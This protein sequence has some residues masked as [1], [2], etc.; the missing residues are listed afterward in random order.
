M[1]YTCE[2]APVHLCGAAAEKCA[3]RMENK[4]IDDSSISSLGTFNCMATSCPVSDKIDEAEKML[5]KTTH[6]KL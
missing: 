6:Q 2:P 5:K 1:I 3:R 4:E